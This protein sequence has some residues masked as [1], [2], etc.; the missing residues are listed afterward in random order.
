MFEGYLSAMV[1]GILYTLSYLILTT[2]S[3]NRS[4]AKLSL[5]ENFKH[6]QKSRE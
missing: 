5:V 4:L 6:I 3:C 1:I 2:H